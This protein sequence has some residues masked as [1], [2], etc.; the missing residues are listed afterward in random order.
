MFKD[1]INEKNWIFNECDKDVQL[2]IQKEYNLPSFIAKSIVNR[3]C[4]NI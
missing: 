3:E 2:R 1:L 4:E